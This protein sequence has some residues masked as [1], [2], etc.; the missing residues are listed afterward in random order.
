MWVSGTLE[1]EWHQREIRTARWCP[2][3]RERCPKLNVGVPALKLLLAV[4]GGA[5]M[6]Y[7]CCRIGLQLRRNCDEL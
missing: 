2:D 1:A 3:Q 5:V 7:E 4:L 6:N